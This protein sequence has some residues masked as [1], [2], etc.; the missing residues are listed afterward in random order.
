MGECVN[1][2]VIAAPVDEVWRRIRNFHDMSWTPAIA[3]LEPV[4]EA[5]ADQ[6]GAKRILNGAFH[7]TLLGLDDLERSFRYQITDGPSPVSKDELLYYYG[8][9]RVL[10][11]TD[12]NASLVIWETRYE[13]KDDAQV[14]QLCDPFYIT[15]LAHLKAQYA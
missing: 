4:G 13:A 15:F 1:S 2:A 10:P 12:E 7:E 3:S 11:V 6:L 8:T 5:R 9:V 14:K